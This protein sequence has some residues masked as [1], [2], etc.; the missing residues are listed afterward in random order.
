MLILRLLCFSLKIADVIFPHNS[1]HLVKLPAQTASEA[2][3]HKA[4][5][6]I[7]GQPPGTVRRDAAVK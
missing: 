3:F 6:K 2:A 4:F 5:R 1:G 7:T